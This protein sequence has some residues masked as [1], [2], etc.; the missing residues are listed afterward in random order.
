VIQKLKTAALVSISLGSI[1]TFLII[2]WLI[3][4]NIDKRNPVQQS[5]ELWENNQAHFYYY[6]RINP[7]FVFYF[8]NPIPELQNPNELLPGDY[9]ISRS[10]YIKQLDSTGAEEIFRYRNI[11]ES[12]N[13]VIYT[14]SDSD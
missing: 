1:V 13:T 12:R 4:P 8:S 10:D 5:R 2:T 14:V 3:L 7:S 11:F 6:Q 9:I